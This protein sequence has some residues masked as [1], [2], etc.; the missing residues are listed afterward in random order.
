MSQGSTYHY[1]DINV[2][3]IS[4]MAPSK[5]AFLPRSHLREPMKRGSLWSWSLPSADLIERMGIQWG[6]PTNFM[7]CNGG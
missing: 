2:Y 5:V 7:G 4:G 1:I 6:S 3:P